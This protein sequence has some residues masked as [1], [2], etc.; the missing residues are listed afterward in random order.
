[1]NI[2]TPLNQVRGL[3]AAKEGTSHF[4]QQRA[5]AVALIPLSLWFLWAV[6]ANVGADYAAV[7][8]WLASPLTSILLLLF[9]GTA[10]HHM[11]L[12]VQVVIEDYIH[13]HSS[14]VA[15]LLLSSFFSYGLAGACIFA[16]L[17]I[18]L[19]S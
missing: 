17:K 14:K 8:A 3:G 10:F 1:M 18:S 2:K 7:S 16:V 4:W 11:K 19:G 9:I 13:T 6:P 12:G 5:T 15:L